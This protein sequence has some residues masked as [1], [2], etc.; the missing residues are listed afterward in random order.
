MAELKT[1]DLSRR[2]G[3]L[4]QNQAGGLKAI[5]RCEAQH[6]ERRLQ[7]PEL[8]CLRT[9]RLK[10]P[11]P[12]MPALTG[13]TGA[14][15]SLYHRLIVRNLRFERSGVPQFPINIARDGLPYHGAGGF[16]QPGIL[17]ALGQRDCT[18]HPAQSGLRA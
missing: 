7:S 13:G 9:R 5:S 3:R 6:W 4:V 11:L 8:A 1:C 12:V 18:S 15:A 10:S 16:E 14:V 2:M 17:K